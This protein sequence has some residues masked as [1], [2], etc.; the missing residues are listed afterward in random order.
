[1]AELRC[2]VCGYPLRSQSDFPAACSHPRVP[3]YNR[4][5]ANGLLV[6]TDEP[7][8]AVPLAELDAPAPPVVPSRGKRRRK[9]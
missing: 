1:M 6:R 8:K 2:C 9:K 5:G 7:L 3:H 4:P